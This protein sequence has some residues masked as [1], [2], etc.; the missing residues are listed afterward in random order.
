MNDVAD[1]VPRYAMWSEAAVVAAL[2]PLAI[3]DGA[4]VGQHLLHAAGDY[5][6]SR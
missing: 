4:V 6:R 1:S 2:L 3:A 5:T